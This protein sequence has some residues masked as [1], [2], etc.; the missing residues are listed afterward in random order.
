[1]HPI[2]LIVLTLC[3]YSVSGEVSKFTYTIQENPD[4]INIL[5]TIVTWGM[6]CCLN[7]ELEF[8]NLSVHGTR[9]GYDNHTFFVL[10]KCNHE[11]D[12]MCS[13]N[14]QELRGEYN[15]TF[16]VYPKTLQIDT[17]GPVTSIDGILYPPGSKHQ[18]LNNSLITLHL[19]WKYPKGYIW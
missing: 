4:N 8:F 12:Y 17:P 18:F 16:S 2:S 14:L 15:Y 13:V 10:E 7:G 6:P 3:T 9:D 19:S 1:M 5:D 11:D